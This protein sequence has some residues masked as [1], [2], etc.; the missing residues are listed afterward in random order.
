M[1]PADDFEALGQMASIFGG[2]KL[3]QLAIKLGKKLHIEPCPPG[4]DLVQFCRMSAA[5]GL[6]LSF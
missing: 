4:V 6:I 5:S 2:D 3:K 1:R